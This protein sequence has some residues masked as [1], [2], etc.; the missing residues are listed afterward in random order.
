M[1][2]LTPAGPPT[3][4]GALRAGAHYA[5]LV[6]ASM[7]GTL[8]R[9]GFNAIG[10]YNGSVI[11]PLAW[12][13]GVGCGVMGL[14]TARKPEVAWIYPPLTTFVTTGIAGSTTTFSSWMLEGFE[15]F[16][17]TPAG[18]FSKT[19]N[20]V[21]YSL[22]T[23]G[24][25][26]AGV[27][28]GHQVSSF[29]PSLP[30][31]RL[32]GKPCRLS[33]TPVVDG[34]ML[35]LAAASYAAALAMYFA[36]PTYWRRHAVFALLL[37]PPGA[38]LRYGLSRLNSGKRVDGRFPLGT[39]IA[40]AAATLLIGGAYAGMRRPAGVV[41]CDAL[42]ALQ[43][44]FCGCLSTVS[45]FVVEARTLRRGWAWGYVLSSVVLGHLLILATV[46]GV[47][48]TEGPIGV[49]TGSDAV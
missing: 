23:F 48:W 42:H 13:Q 10:D 31:P 28:L 12:A 43:D 45:T 17:D 22:A 32:L 9:L 21:A 6:L 16:A 34:L 33:P 46:G 39:F 40:N 14:G 37:S 7:L 11:F 30:R 4:Y 3:E 36:A 47:R 26:Y 18:G 5:T 41:A 8:I 25:S 1:T 38:M 29:L 35:L 19:V 20:G 15:A 24:I 2:T 49:C 27:V 44:G